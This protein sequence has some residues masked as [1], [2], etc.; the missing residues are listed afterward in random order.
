MKSYCV[1]QKKVTE[2]TQPSGYKTA[3]NGRQKMFRCTCA[4]CGIKKTRFVSKSG[5]GLI[6]GKNSPFKDTPVLGAIL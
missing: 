3:K 2:C 4:E 6:L 5:K 1:K